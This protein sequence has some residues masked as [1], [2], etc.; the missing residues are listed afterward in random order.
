[1]PTNQVLI[2]YFKACIEVAW[3]SAVQCPPLVIDSS[4]GNDFNTDLFEVYKTKG[5]Y[6]EY[7]VRAFL[8]L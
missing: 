2:E 7:L 4:P 8:Y 1:M 5:P 3:F 6:V